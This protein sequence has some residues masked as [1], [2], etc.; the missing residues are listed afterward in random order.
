V[1]WTKGEY[2]MWRGDTPHIAANV[3]STNR[4]TMQITAHD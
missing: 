1:N 4:Y 2:I 3:G